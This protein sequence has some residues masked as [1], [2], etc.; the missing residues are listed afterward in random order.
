[1]NRVRTED[2]LIEMRHHAQALAVASAWSRAGYF[3]A[4]A[5]GQPRPLA[6][7]GGDA[8]ALEITAQILAHIGLLQGDGRRWA[9]TSTA[10]TML[11]AGELE[12][13]SLG[14][15]FDDWSRIDQMLK[16]GGPATS[17][18]GASRGTSGGVREDKPN[19]ARGFMMMLYRRSAAAAEE[20]ARWMC[21]RLQPGARILDLG[22]GHGRY[23]RALVERG[24]HATLFDR[25]V[26]VSL[27]RELHGDALSYRAGDF[28]KDDL[29]GPYD[30]VFLSNIVHGCSEQEIVALFGRLRAVVAPAGL[31]VIKDMF[32]DELGQQP[33][34]AV[35]FG[36]TMLMFTSGGRS[37]DARTM[38]TLL[39][40]AGWQRPEMIAVDE[41]ALMFTRPA[42]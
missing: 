39:A 7:L 41:F 17:R 19:E 23:A 15:L 20:S 8:R 2:D 40:T 14:D 27:A 1:M 11:A 9:L 24:M 32:I 3:A 30:A 5:D 22:G 26:C 12:L 4:L 33:R 6:D 34:N 42:A 18:D 29:G 28:M 36:L 35:M 25:D 31:A 21:E 38:E 13:G 37:Y 10:R 16:H